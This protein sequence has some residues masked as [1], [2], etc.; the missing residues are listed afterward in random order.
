MPGVHKVLCQIQPMVLGTPFLQIGAE[1][2]LL[3]LRHP[4]TLGNFNH[5][6]KADHSFVNSD[7]MVTEFF[8]IMIEPLHFISQFQRV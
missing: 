2:W 5:G 3:V 1:K 4:L 8:K 7:N 6:F